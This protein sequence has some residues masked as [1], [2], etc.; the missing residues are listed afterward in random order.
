MS[1]PLRR[2]VYFGVKRKGAPPCAGTAGRAWS[3]RDLRHRTRAGRGVFTCP[4]WVGETFRSTW[5]TGIESS[6]QKAMG[7]L[8]DGC[9]GPAWMR[10]TQ[11]HCD[12]CPRCPSLHND[13]DAFSQQDR[14]RNVHHA[15]RP[16]QRLADRARVR[17]VA[18]W[19][20]TRRPA[21]VITLGDRNGE[22][23][24]RGT[25][26]MATS[27]GGLRDRSRFAI[28][29]TAIPVAKAGDM[30][31][32]RSVTEHDHPTNEADTKMPES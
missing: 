18:R 25:T 12:R 28:S 11:A 10:Q 2:A 31:P 4:A 26:L 16:R 22:R 23:L 19:R 1:R 14:W 7:N 27:D 3:N 6:S 20:R 21:I 24:G 8:S 32:R 9:R 29:S 30:Q 5:R 15:G 17:V 13:G